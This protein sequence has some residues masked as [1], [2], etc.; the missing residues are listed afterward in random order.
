MTQDF[1]EEYVLENRVN[2]EPQVD[3][4]PVFSRELAPRIRGLSPMEAALEVNLWCAEHVTYRF[5]DSPT[6]DP[7]TIYY[8]GHGRCGEESVFTVAALRSAGI[9]A[10]Q[11]YVPRWSHCDDNHAWVEVFVDGGWHYLGACEPE[12]VLDRGWFTSPAARA[13]L[14]RSRRRDGTF[15]NQTARYAP[16]QTWHFH[17]GCPGAKITLWLLNDNAF[18]PIWSMEANSQGD[19]SEELGIGDLLVTVQA[20]GVWGELLC[21]GKQA[22][23]FTI[24]LAAPSPHPSRTLG[25]PSPHLPLT[26]THTLRFEAPDPPKTYPKPLSPPQQARRAEMLAQAAQRRAQ[27]AAAHR[28]EAETPCRPGGQGFLPPLDDR[29][30][31]A[32]RLPCGDQLF[33]MGPPGSELTRPTASLHQL[34]RPNPL[35]MRVSGPCLLAWVRPGEEPTAHFLNELSA[36]DGGFPVKLRLSEGAPPE[37]LP[38]TLGLDPEALPLLALAGSDGLCYYATNGYQVG[39]VSLIAQLARLLP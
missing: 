10:R 2:D 23:D 32:T 25:I 19:A 7:L 35:P 33:V 37:E 29:G 4:R 13:M 11:V 21:K 12:P 34:L 28:E 22:S 31:A 26:P 18:H 15:E 39:S 20:P 36:F 24:P 1:L 14:V 38:R 5:N 3:Y 17:T 6:A 9:P 16:T 30:V 27:W 8:R